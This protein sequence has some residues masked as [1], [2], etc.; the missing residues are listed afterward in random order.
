MSNT[1]KHNKHKRKLNRRMRRR[2]FSRGKK[3]NDFRT[4]LSGRTSRVARAPVGQRETRIDRAAS[5][6]HE[7]VCARAYTRH[8]YR[9]QGA[10]FVHRAVK[11][12][13]WNKITEAKIL[14]K[15][16]ELVHD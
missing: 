1:K 14:I 16:F 7:R 13:G 4:N 15:I 9:R 12:T 6:R 11:H 8:L 10:R 5:R 3:K 2:Q